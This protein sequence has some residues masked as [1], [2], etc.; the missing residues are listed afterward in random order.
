MKKSHDGDVLKCEGK[1]L[2][3]HNL[4]IHLYA[5]ATQ[6]YIFFKTKDFKF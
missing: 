3:R 2:K 1:A 4:E 5:D 6:I